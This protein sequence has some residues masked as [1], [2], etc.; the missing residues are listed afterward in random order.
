MTNTDTTNSGESSPATSQS[1]N[2]VLEARRQAAAQ[3]TPLPEDVPPDTPAAEVAAK[4]AAPPGPLTQAD[5]DRMVA[6]ALQRAA[7]GE[8]PPA[9]TNPGQGAGGADS[10]TQQA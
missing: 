3:P 6:Q 10:A 8:T 5:V 4:I 1:W 2:D 9:D 7:A